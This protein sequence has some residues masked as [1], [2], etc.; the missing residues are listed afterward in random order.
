ME[1]PCLFCIPRYHATEYA[2]G[3]QIEGQ[4]TAQWSVFPATRY[5]TPSS[6]HAD[7]QTEVE[8]LQN[9]LP[10]SSWLPYNTGKAL[11][12]GISSSF[13]SY[14]NEYFGVGCA[15]V[16]DDL[17]QQGGKWEFTSSLVTTVSCQAFPSQ[18][19]SKRPRVKLIY[20]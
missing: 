6:C 2:H 18:L 4:T 3:D 20:R 19:P 12:L 11:T 17:A 16:G 1:Y 9:I 7:G 8:L 10:L 5:K 14:Q 13:K 15:S